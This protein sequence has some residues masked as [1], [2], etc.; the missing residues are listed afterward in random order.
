[1]INTIEIV[2]DYS[3]RLRQNHTLIRSID[4]SP[5]CFFFFFTLVTG[6]GK[7]LSLTFLEP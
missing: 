2:T 5:G 4:E 7:S 6:Y 1:M 3:R